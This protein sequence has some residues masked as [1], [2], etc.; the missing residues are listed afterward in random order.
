[1]NEYNYANNYNE[2]IDENYNPNA[3][4]KGMAITAFV[5]CLVNL[6]C[7]CGLFT[8]FVAVPLSLILSIITLA[9]RRGGKGFAIASL[10]ISAISAVILVIYIS[11]FVKIY[12]DIEYF[13]KNDTEIIEKY[14]AT[15]EIPE[16]Y[17]K[18]R[19]SEYDEFWNAMQYENFDAFFDDFI[20]TYKNSQRNNKG[21]IKD[22]DSNSK[23]SDDYNHDGEQ[24]VDLSA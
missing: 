18:Y 8:G 12:P 19:D 2:S 1:M 9:T 22:K 5:I 10:I 21:S 20:L 17:E 23:E 16:Q 24:L 13:I 4:K 3:D 14:E 7:F 6:F 11:A 15:G